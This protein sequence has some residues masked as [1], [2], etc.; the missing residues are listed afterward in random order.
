MIMYRVKK[1]LNHNSVIAV[2]ANQEYLIMGK[3][4]GFGKKVSERFDIPEGSECTIY[5]LQEQTERG[6]AMEI[7]K[8]IEPIYLEIAGQILAKSETV[9]GRIYG[10]RQE[11]YGSQGGSQARCGVCRYR[12]DG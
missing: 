2:K 10:V 11:H 9:F 4:I 7:I 3:G 6:K 1:V 8:G 5:S 12:H